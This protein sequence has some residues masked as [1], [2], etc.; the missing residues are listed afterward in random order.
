MQK[1]HPEVDQPK[2]PFT[3]IP[4]CCAEDEEE[5]SARARAMIVE[6]CMFLLVSGRNKG[7]GF[8]KDIIS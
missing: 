1:Q 7:E 2:P 5:K 3:H 8:R 4:S 6:E